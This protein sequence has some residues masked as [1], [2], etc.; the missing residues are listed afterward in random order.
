MP[1]PRH[2]LVGFLMALTLVLVGCGAQQSR[3]GSLTQPAQTDSPSP[4]ASGTAT[5]APETSPV[6]T[7]A[8]THDITLYTVLAGDTLASIARR[9][10]TSV[11]Q[12]QAWNQAR[13]P[14]LATNPG[15]LLVGW[16]LVV[17][18]EP[19][20]TPL[21]TPTVPASPLPV[22]ACHAGNRAAAS[23][24]AVYRSIPGAGAEVALTFDMGGRLDPALQIMNLLV[25]NKVCATIFPTGA[26]SQTAIGQQV[27]AIIKAHSELFE[28][29]NHTM[30]HC[31]LA[32]GGQ[33]SPTTAPCAGGPPSAAFVRKELTDAAAILK[34]ATGQ[35]PI[36]YWRPPYGSYDQAVLD[37]AASVGYTKTLLWDVDTIDWMPISQGGPTAQQ[38]ANKVVGNAANG[39][40]V[41]MHLGGYETFD[42]LKIM[43][44]GLRHR[45]FTLTSIS[46]QLDGR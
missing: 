33:G 37:A 20:V 15:T 34:A 1:Y 39:S 7:P 13:Y 23:P 41:L 9:F 40:V 29:G 2:G 32:R 31:D 43:I 16:E 8:E 21:P 4:T 45:G 25:A 5:V 35:S 10:A 27:L 6:E 44:P 38:I 28:V 18:G 24:R 19:G 42:A 26:M 46:D 14:S 30:H 3:S 17:A 22:A 12:L 11:E 36:P